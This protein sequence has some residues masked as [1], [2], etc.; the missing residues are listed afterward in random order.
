MTQPDLKLLKSMALNAMRT[1]M[2]C[3]GYYSFVNKQKNILAMIE[4]IE[5]LEKVAKW[6]CHLKGD[7]IAADDHPTHCNS[8]FGFVDALDELKK[9]K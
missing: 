9:T 6:A 7:F 5:K 4:R 2:V 1:G 8:Y 3:E